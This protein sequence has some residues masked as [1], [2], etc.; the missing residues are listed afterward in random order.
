[1]DISSHKKDMAIHI[2]EKTMSIDRLIM[3]MYNSPDKIVYEHFRAVNPHL[4]DN[5]VKVGQVVLLSP[6]NS[7]ECT[8][9]EAQFLS[10]ANAVDK[11]LMELDRAE[12]EILVKRYDFLSNVASYNGLLLG[13]S[14][15]VWN[16]HVTQVKSILK[17]IEKTY[18]SSFNRSGNLNN[19][20][21]F[22]KRN[23]QFQRLNTAL[24]RF[25]QPTINDNLLAGD[26]K[27]NLG[28]S[29]KSILH[30]WGK[31]QGTVTAI[32]DF[33]KNYA[34][35]AK[36]SRNLK[37]VG[38]V[39]IALTGV[40]AAASIEKACTVKDEKQCTETKYSQIGKASASIA[41]G[42]AGGMLATWGVC[43]LVFGL[44]SGGTSAF[45][46]SVVAGGT[47]GYL[48]GKYGGSTGEYLG[49]ELYKTQLNK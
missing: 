48:G 20:Q 46:C 18:I 4:K 42:T 36:M 16:S 47:G 32:P 38:Y 17:D 23:I 45:W 27:K 35:V 19:Q 24:K 5:M 39:S 1:M 2:V 28:L 21:F 11:S 29:S 25:G 9:E 8:L 26:I 44:P 15:N 33:A 31:Q 49:T 7:I 30:R 14:N 37:R 10:L 3:I 6:A 43:T 12:R 13:V 22:S 34:A 40:E 41:G